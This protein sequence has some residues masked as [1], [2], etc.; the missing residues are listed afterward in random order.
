MSDAVTFVH[1]RSY[2]PLNIAF[3]AP[4]IY[5]GKIVLVLPPLDPTPLSRL[6][7][8]EEPVTVSF[9]VP[10]AKGITALQLRV[11]IVR[12]VEKLKAI[13]Q[14]FGMPLRQ[15][16]LRRLKLE[17]FRQARARKKGKL[18]NPEVAL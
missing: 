5:Q 15:A 13:S 18:I 12:D 6:T 9:N 11:L 4:G 10:E 8:Q 17:R 2:Q 16:E 14:R 3:P 1:I 7:S